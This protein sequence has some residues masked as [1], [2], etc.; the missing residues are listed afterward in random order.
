MDYAFETH[1][2]ATVSLKSYSMKP[3][4]IFWVKDRERADPDLICGNKGLDRGLHIVF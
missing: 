4:Y 2:I 1:W 3:L